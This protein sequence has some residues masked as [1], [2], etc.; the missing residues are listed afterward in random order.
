MKKMT[1]KRFVGFNLE[2][3]EYMKL[4]DEAFAKKVNISTLLREILRRKQGGSS[5]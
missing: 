1:S 4:R 3:Q 5:G 2:E